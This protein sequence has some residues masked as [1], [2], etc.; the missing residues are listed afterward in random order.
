VKARLLDR[1]ASI[2]SLPDEDG[3]LMQRICQPFTRGETGS[4][5][6]LG[7][8]MVHNIV[9]S[10]LGGSVQ[11]E[12]TPGVGTIV[13]VVLPTGV[14]ALTPAAWIEQADT[15]GI[16]AER[17]KQEPCLHEIAS[18][19][20][21][22][23]KKSRTLGRRPSKN[24]EIAVMRRRISVASGHPSTETLRRSRELTRLCSPKVTH[25]TG[26]PRAA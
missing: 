21:R 6:G 12:S 4:G 16:G 1:V 15:V 14:A 22:N 24:G 26:S 11:V 3:A 17:A 2:G 9:T 13:R 23:G 19:R 20:R 18:L 25:P 10:L 7:M 8:H 5:T